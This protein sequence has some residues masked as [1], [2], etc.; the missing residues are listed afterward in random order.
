M[1]AG[2]FFK[3]LIYIYRQL[4]VN[5]VKFTCDLT[6]VAFDTRPILDKLI[7]ILFFFYFF[8][9][10]IFFLLEQVY[11]QNFINTYIQNT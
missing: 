2:P 6:H 10:F 4:D 9:Y 1:F 8:F 3:P 11:C 5:S 7:V